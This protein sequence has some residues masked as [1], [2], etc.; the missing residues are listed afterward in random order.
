MD[1]LFKEI[2]PDKALILNAKK[3]QTEHFNS[4]NINYPHL[5]Y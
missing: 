3:K 1:F 2:N 5:E 4:V